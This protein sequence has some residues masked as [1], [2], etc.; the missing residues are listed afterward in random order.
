MFLLLPFPFFSPPH[1]LLHLV[2]YSVYLISETLLWPVSSCFLTPNNCFVR[3]PYLNDLIFLHN[4]T[5]LAVW[6]IC[7]LR[8]LL[9]HTLHFPG[10]KLEVRCFQRPND[11]DGTCDSFHCK[12]FAEGTM[13]AFATYSLQ[14]YQS[15]VI[16][17]SVS[18]WCMLCW[19][20]EIQNLVKDL[21]WNECL[22]L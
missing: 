12:F 22:D 15:L 4:S 2:T 1:F 21:P 16:M 5:K 10:L 9:M 11:D 6:G 18:L 3:S 19:M 17:Q 7:I 8:I 20:L 13:A 14:I